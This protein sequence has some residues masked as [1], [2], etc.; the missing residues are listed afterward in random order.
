MEK[1]L[2]IFESTL[3]FNNV[4]P[5]SL[6]LSD[7][8]T[9]LIYNK[10]H[11]SLGDLSPAEI[12]KIASKFDRIEFV[13]RLF[14]RKSTDFYEIKILLNALSHR[15][16]VTNW[17]LASKKNF[18]W[19]NAISRT[20]S[21][22]LWAFGCSHTW[23]TGLADLSTR[24]A[25]I[26][27]DKLGLPACIVAEPG[28]SIDWSL[29]QLMFADIE[30]KDTVVWQLTT[31]DRFS[32]LENYDDPLLEV[33]LKNT[34]VHTVSFWSDEQLFFKQISFLSMGVRHLEKL[35]CGFAIIS[36][37]G[38][39]DLDYRLLEE[40]AKYPEYCYLPGFDVDLAED[41]LHVGPKSHANLA[42]GI[43][44]HLKRLYD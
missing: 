12:L 10:Y 44:E 35:G 36:L 4:D 1:V 30:K 40:Y 11:T 22:V 21:P 41:R 14:D 37:N 6:L 13:D 24:Y 27:G 3:D 29:R 8:E 15:M 42:R 7:V 19:E 31:P 38:Q 17:D 33:M 28:S 5:E 2:Y 25:E 34:D 43:H 9:E 32:K 16:P 18:A 20:N 26:L 39:S 23:G